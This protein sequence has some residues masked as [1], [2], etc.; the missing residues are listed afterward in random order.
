MTT[1][2]QWFR[3]TAWTAGSV[4]A[5][6]FV[7]VSATQW[8]LGIDLQRRPSNPFRVYLHERGPVPVQRGD[9][10]TFRPRGVHWLGQRRGF[11]VK[12][13]VAM[14]GDR[15]EVRR[16][17]LEV[18]GVPA[19]RID[20]VI[21]ARVGLNESPLADVGAIPEGS[22]LVLGDSPA[23]FDGRYIGLL[24]VAE[25]TGKAWPLW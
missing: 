25:V 22:L 7:A 4:L 14:G 18:N 19:G 20:P 12:R 3:V 1:R 2:R 21:L 13:I 16:G 10:V 8:G 17:R 6:M 24:P 23:S 5:W 9:F 15:L 11:F